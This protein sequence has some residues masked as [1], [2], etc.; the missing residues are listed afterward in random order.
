MHQAFLDIDAM[1][2]I[3]ASSFHELEFLMKQLESVN[4]LKHVVDFKF[5]QVQSQQRQ[6]DELFRNSPKELIMKNHS[7]Y[8]NL[9]QENFIYVCAM[10][11]HFI[12]SRFKIYLAFSYHFQTTKPKLQNNQFNCYN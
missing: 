2:G 1:K 5:E 8:L 3:V 9:L 10:L 4:E 7:E 11:I 12:Y 6:V